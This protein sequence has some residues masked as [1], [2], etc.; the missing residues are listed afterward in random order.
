MEN[1]GCVYFFRHTGLKPVKIGY[2]ISISPI[3]RFNQFKTYAPFGAEILGFIITENPNELEKLLHEK[4]SVFRLHGEWFDISEEMVKKAISFHSN[5]FQIHSRFKF[6]LEFAK[7]LSQK[8][9]SEKTES[10]LEKIISDL[11]IEDNSKFLPTEDIISIINSY[12]E[13]KFTSIMIGRTLKQMGFTKIREGLNERR[14]GYQ[15][16]QIK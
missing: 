8:K 7:Y 3:E 15:I 10:Y 11:F 2:S 13:Q 4:F 16:R 1:Q 9:E 14:Y 12:S 5:E 6:E